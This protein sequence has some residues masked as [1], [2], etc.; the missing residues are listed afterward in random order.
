MN[1][2]GGLL[3]IS[4]CGVLFLSFY[5]FFGA[6]LLAGLIKKSKFGA[7][8]CGVHQKNNIQKACGV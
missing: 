6:G 3:A 7:G 8:N 1:A 2:P 5:S 4:G